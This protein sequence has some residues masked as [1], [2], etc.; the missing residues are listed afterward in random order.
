VTNEVVRLK[1]ELKL[2]KQPGYIPDFPVWVRNCLQDNIELVII[3]IYELTDD[4]YVGSVLTD[5]NTGADVFNVL[6]SEICT[7]RMLKYL[8][9]EGTSPCY[10]CDKD[11]TEGWFFRNT[12]GDFLLCC[13]CLI[14]N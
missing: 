8:C 11:V 4:T 10:T 12:E 9:L 5:V 13:S 14:G 1:E 2:N 7:W 3:L 6:S